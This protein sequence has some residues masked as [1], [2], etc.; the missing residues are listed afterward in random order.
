MGLLK[1]NRKNEQQPLSDL[2][3][4]FNIQFKPLVA[5][6]ESKVSITNAFAHIK[7]SHDF[8]LSILTKNGTIKV[9]D[10]KIHH[11]IVSYKGK[12]SFKNGKL[13]LMP[14]ATILETN[15]SGA[16]EMFLKENIQYS[17]NLESTEYNDYRLNIHDLV[18]LNS[19]LIHVNELPAGNRLSIR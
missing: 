4:L 8:D 9:Y 3:Q 15:N 5:G 7:N 18:G 14:D 6:V 2:A 10:E 17:L 16:F 11:G 12:R 13:K 19:H 1:V